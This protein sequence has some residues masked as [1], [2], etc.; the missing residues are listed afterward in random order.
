M[1]VFLCWEPTAAL[2]VGRN[3]LRLFLNSPKNGSPEIS[4]FLESLKVSRVSIRMNYWNER[5]DMNQFLYGIRYGGSKFL[6]ASYFNPVGYPAL[7]IQTQFKFNGSRNSKEFW[8]MFLGV[9]GNPLPETNSSPPENRPCQKEINLP[10]IN[11]Q[12]QPV[13]FREC[14]HI[15]MGLANQLDYINIWCSHVSSMLHLWQGLAGLG[16]LNFFLELGNKWMFRFSCFGVSLRSI[17]GWL[18]I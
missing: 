16:L 18:V 4:E 10:S 5:V 9:K 14:N 17:R 1:K 7:K 12:E 6:L 15:R 2:F 13:S 8:S 11:F 3:L